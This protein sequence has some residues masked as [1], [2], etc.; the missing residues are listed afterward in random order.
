MTHPNTWPGTPLRRLLTLGA[1]GALSALLA[2]CGGSGNDD[3]VTPTTLSGVAALGAP[4]AGARIT[5]VDSQGQ[6][7]TATA[8]AQGR[9]TLAA[10]GLQAP[11]LLSVIEA[12]NNSNCRYNNTPRAHCLAAYLP[13]LRANATNVAN[14][15]PL[16]DRV[17]SDLAVGLKFI[18]PQQM[19]ESGKAPAV[20]GAALDTAMSLMRAGFKAALSEAGVANVDA[21]DPVSTP[22]ETNGKGVDAVLDVINHTRNYDN[23]SGE[24]AHTV[25]TDISFRPIVGLLGTGSYEPLDYTRAAKELAEIKAASVR[26]L[27]VGDSTAA[28]YE[29]ERLPRMGWGQ[30]FES[31]FKAGSGVKVLNGARAGRSSRDFYNG[32]WYGQMARFMKAGDYVIIN[33]GHNDQNCDASKAVRGAADV[34]NLCSYPNTAGGLRQ[35]P[36]G[37][38]GMSFQASLETYIQSAR[39]AGAT[40][41]IMTP[42]TR[43]WNVDRKTAYQS[44]DTRPVVPNHFTSQN[45]ANGFAFIGDYSQTVKDT[46]L[47]NAIP[48]IDLEAKSIV[49][50]NAHSADWKSY[51]LAIDPT[52]ARY[53]YYKT[54]SSGTLASPDTTHFQEAGAHAMADLVVQ[55]IKE[56]PALAALATWLK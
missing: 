43:Y 49:F 11:L 39:A 2:A 38:P 46:A 19:V 30:V 24:S 40:P 20:S 41:F 28:T 56:T 25:L 26:V 15:N 54:Q 45:A 29:L 9:Y 48:L 8:D 27:V 3:P 18:G 5:V 12:G 4:L 53:P 37:K 23:N 22:M 47:A 6:K 52:D 13:S 35:F 17:A 31:K 32:G 50:A 7:K 1:V 14:L 44:G 10:D 55:G 51:W 33:H 42:T 36:T 34:A 16:T 21:F